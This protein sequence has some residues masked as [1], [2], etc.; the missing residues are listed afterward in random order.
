M[1]S[2][3]DGMTYNEIAMELG[4]S[5]KTVEYHISKAL[6]ILRSELGDY[7][8]LSPD[9]PGDPF[10]LEYPHGISACAYGDY[11]RSCQWAYPNGW[12]PLQYLAV[13]GLLRYGYDADARRIA[14]KYLDTVVSTFAETDNLWE[15][16]NVV[17]GNINV[18]NE[19]EMPAMLGWT[20]GTFRV[21]S[22]LL[23]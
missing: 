11:R 18:S 19:Y 10:R 2:R 23:H 17:E 14:V 15:K 13:K 12:A 4:I 1:L 8:P 9:A 5:E 6:K 21:L 7:L 22:E 16:Y 20:A 3:F